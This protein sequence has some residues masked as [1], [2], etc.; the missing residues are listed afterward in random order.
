MYQR[1]K[2]GDGLYEKSINEAVGNVKR[3]T[4]SGAFEK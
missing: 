2:V 4:F 3:A 1:C